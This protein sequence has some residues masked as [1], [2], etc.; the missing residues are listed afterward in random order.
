MKKEENSQRELKSIY[1]AN[2]NEDHSLNSNSISLLKLVI[3]KNHTSSQTPFE[4]D[5]VDEINV[6]N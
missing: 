4:N 6:Y 1:F 2:Y 5:E 3:H